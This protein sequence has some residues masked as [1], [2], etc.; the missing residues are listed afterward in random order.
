MKDA[1]KKKIIV[2]RRTALST[3]VAKKNFIAFYRIIF[4]S[5]TLRQ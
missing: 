2:N 1:I 5:H 3:C 4:I